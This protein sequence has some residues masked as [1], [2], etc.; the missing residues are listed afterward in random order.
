MGRIVIISPGANLFDSEYDFY[1][2]NH[3]LRDTI[4]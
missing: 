4:N 2:L 1:A 3:C